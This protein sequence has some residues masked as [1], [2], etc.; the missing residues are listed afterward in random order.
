MQ[1]GSFSV[2]PGHQQEFHGLLR[3]RVICGETLLSYFFDRRLKFAQFQEE[4]AVF[5]C[6]FKGKGRGVKIAVLI[7]GQLFFTYREGCVVFSIF[8]PVCRR[9][10]LNRSRWIMADIFNRLVAFPNLIALFALSRVVV[11]E[12]EKYFKSL[13]AQKDRF[14]GVYFQNFIFFASLFQ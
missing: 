11:K 9:F 6:K 2:F 3:K 7:S 1:V 8:R 5:S 14:N 12:T 13:E 10:P 4:L